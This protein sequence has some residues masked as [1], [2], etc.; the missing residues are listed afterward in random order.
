M[1]H[2]TV[3]CIQLTPH[4]CNF[5]PL[6]CVVMQNYRHR[7]RPNL[8]L[9]CQCGLLLI[10]GLRDSDIDDQVT[11]ARV[12]GRMN[13][14][15]YISLTRQS[16]TGSVASSPLSCL[17]KVDHSIISSIALK[18]NITE[19]LIW[20]ALYSTSMPRDYS[21]NTPQIARERWALKLLEG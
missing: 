12:S 3:Y 16:R 6:Q 8:D 18:Y 10:F 13:S 14:L 15:E 2:D 5:I 17:F 20:Q 7:I 21:G 11:Y 19:T 4:A 1:G 9:V